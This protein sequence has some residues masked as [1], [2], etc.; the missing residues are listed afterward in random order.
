MVVKLV[1]TLEEAIKNKKPTFSQE[2]IEKFKYAIVNRMIGSGKSNTLIVSKKTSGATLNG[3][4]IDMFGLRQKLIEDGF[5][6]SGWDEKLGKPV[7]ESKELSILEAQA[8]ADQSRRR[9]IG[10]IL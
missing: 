8:E 9:K 1:G 3:K 2:T 4:F 10:V 5:L 7:K 6:L